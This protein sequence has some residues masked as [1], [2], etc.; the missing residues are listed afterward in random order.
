[1]ANRESTMS[2]DGCVSKAH[3]SVRTSENKFKCSEASNSLTIFLEAIYV[4]VVSA[5]AWSWVEEPHSVCGHNRKSNVSFVSLWLETHTKITCNEYLS[6]I[7]AGKPPRIDL[8]I[9]SAQRES[10]RQDWTCRRSDDPR[11]RWWSAW[12][13]TFGRI[14]LLPSWALPF[15]EISQGL[16]L[17]EQKTSRRP[18]ALTNQVDN[19][20]MHSDRQNLCMSFF[21]SCFKYGTQ[22]HILVSGASK[23]C[24]EINKRLSQVKKTKL[25]RR[26]ILMG[27]DLLRAMTSVKKVKEHTSMT[28]TTS[29]L[30][31]TAWTKTNNKM[32]ARATPAMRANTSTT[33]SGESIPRSKADA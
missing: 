15:C 29:F 12:P 14:V 25:R 2:A 1:M 33:K 31:V 5:W 6:G 32:H 28:A 17:A 18:Q 26:K 23:R 30:Y 19:S 24:H 13:A 4:A 8:V 20:F 21:P 27:K 7:L 10:F 9:F 3:S 16:R 11:V 22:I